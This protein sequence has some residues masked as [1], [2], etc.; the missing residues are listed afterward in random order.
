MWNFVQF[1]QFWSFWQF[2]I[3]KSS[4]KQLLSRCNQE[5][6]KPPVVGFGV[7]LSVG[8]RVATALED[9]I[10]DDSDKLAALDEADEAR[11]EVANVEATSDAEDD[12]EK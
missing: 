1:W 10:L 3:V 4:R 7:A 12:A 9:A 2:S 8:A 11:M 6:D 5:K